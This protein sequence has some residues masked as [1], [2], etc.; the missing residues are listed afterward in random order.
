MNWLK[1]KEKSNPIAF[2]AE[3]CLTH[4]VIFINLFPQTMLI[5]TEF[6]GCEM[7]SLKRRSMVTMYLEK[8]AKTGYYGFLELL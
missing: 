2:L 5:N 1:K 6:I 8:D 3:D 7:I 4:G